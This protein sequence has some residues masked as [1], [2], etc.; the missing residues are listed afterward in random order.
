MENP[1]PSGEDVTRRKRNPPRNIP[2]HVCSR[3]NGCTRETCA[4]QRAH[5]ARIEAEETDETPGEES[6]DLGYAF[7]PDVPRARR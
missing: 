1:L 2:G 6:S 4:Q 3:S 7:R 5:A